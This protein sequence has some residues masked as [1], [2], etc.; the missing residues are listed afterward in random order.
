[1]GRKRTGYIRERNGRFEVWV[2]GEYVG[3]YDDEPKAQRMKRAALDEDAGKAPESFGLFA[4]DWIDKRELAAQRR[5]RSRSFKRERSRWNAHVTTAKF[6]DLPWKRITPKAVQEWVSGLFEKEAVRVVRSQGETARVGTGRRVSRRVVEDALSLV[7]LCLDAA[8]VAGKFS[9]CNNQNPARLV[10]MPRQ[11]VPEHEGDLI[12]HM[13]AEE[14]ERLFALE[15]PAFQRAVFTVAIYAGLR[16]EELW[17]LRWQ[18]LVLTGK[19]PEIRIRKTYNGDPVKTKTSIRDVPLLPPALE[20]L[21]AWKAEQATTPIAGLVFPRKDGGSH[22][23]F[24]TAGWRDKPRRVTKADGTKELRVAPGWR[25][26]AGIRPE[27]DFR[28]LR[29]TCGCHLLQGTWTPR[30][31]T[32][33]EVSRWLGHSSIKVTERHYAA[34]TSDN[35]HNAVDG[36]QRAWSIAPDKK[37]I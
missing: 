13:W 5:K 25:T 30:P 26:R 9:W 32:L 20:A 14:I 1:M 12:V 29:H 33:A 6:W 22:D 2:G 3:I 34:L 37:D 15:L 16:L 21:K 35:L 18:D 11:E 36:S 24:Y 8:V 7:K 27:I 4:A 23:E 17:G 19:R 10:I 28:D 31:L